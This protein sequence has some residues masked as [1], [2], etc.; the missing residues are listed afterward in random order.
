MAYAA[1]IV[2]WSIKDARGRDLVAARKFIKFLKS[3][4]VVLS[5]RKI[6]NLKSYSLISFNDA[7][8]AN[9]KNSDS[10]GS[11]IMLLEGSSGKYRPLGWHSRK[12]KRFVKITLTVET[13]PLQE[14]IELLVVIKYMF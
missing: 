6:D 12:L 5:F 1:S 2:S 4:D 11:L 13:P 3:E 14:S 7:S 9:L 8:I 10:Q